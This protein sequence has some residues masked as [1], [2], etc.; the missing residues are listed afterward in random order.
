MIYKI[1]AK[2]TINGNSVSFSL[3]KDDFNYYY[4]DN[5]E[6][7]NP[8]VIADNT[9]REICNQIMLADSPMHSLKPGETADFKTMSYEG[10]ITCN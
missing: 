2:N 3:K 6:K 7:I 5:N 1:S 10:K 9:I 8:E 4:E